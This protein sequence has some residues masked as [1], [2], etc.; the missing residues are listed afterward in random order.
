MKSECHLEKRASVFSLVPFCH[1]YGCSLR[2]YHARRAANWQG[3]AARA[4]A[5]F[6][7]GMGKVYPVVRGGKRKV[8]PRQRASGRRRVSRSGVGACRAMHIGPATSIPALLVCRQ[9]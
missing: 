3:N 7:P 8:M 2:C 6:A 4:S 9:S 5:S 1:P